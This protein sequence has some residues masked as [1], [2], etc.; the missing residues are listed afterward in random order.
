VVCELSRRLASVFL[1]D[2]S[3][4]RPCHGVE[5]RFAK[6]PHWRALLVLNEYFHGDNGRGVGARF[7]GWR[8]LVARCLEG[9]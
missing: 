4:R 8:S 9:V 2:A 1:P 3:G 5:T 6:D 7:Q